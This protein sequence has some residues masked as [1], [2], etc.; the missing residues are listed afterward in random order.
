MQKILLKHFILQIM[1]LVHQVNHQDQVEIEIK[2]K[3][4]RKVV[5]T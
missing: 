2:I 5:L 4:A 3:Q 1:Y